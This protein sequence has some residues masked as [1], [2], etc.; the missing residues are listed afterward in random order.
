MGEGI[1]TPSLVILLALRLASA[2]MAMVCLSGPIIQ[3]L[4]RD[5]W[6]QDVVLGEETDS[7]H[8]WGPLPALG[9]IPSDQVLDP[10]PEGLF[11]PSGVVASEEASLAGAI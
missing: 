11:H 5:V 7:Y 9:L 10:T 6:N 2:V 8:L 1:S 3:C 4:L